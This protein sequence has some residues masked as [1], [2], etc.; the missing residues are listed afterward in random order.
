MTVSGFAWSF[1]EEARCR[2][3]TTVSFCQRVGLCL[4]RFLHRSGVGAKDLTRS[5][6]ARRKEGRKWS[7]SSGSYLPK[8]TSNPA[9]QSCREASEMGK[10]RALIQW[11]KTQALLADPPAKKVSGES[12]ESPSFTLRPWR[13]SVDP[14]VARCSM[15]TVSTIPGH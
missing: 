14:V 8:E 10:W 1:A 2:R 5:R 4:Q 15:T 11:C 9:S 6:G 7:S 13:I 12:K 3:S